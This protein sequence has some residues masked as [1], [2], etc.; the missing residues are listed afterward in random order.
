MT[1]DRAESLRNLNLRIRDMRDDRERL[2]AELA[3]LD[4]RIAEAEGVRRALVLTE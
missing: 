4:A 3:A 2:A 1:A